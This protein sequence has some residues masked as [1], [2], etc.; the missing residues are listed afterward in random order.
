MSTKTELKPKAPP[1]D[2]AKWLL[3]AAIIVAIIVGNSIYANESPLY[4]VLA[5]LAASALAVVIAKS[6]VL[7]ETIWVTLRDSY[8]EIRRVVWPTKKETNQTAL[9]V[10]VLTLVSA[11]VLLIFDSIFKWLFSFILG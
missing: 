2:W 6:T 10:I 7:G 8:T 4:R 3:V 9:I 11:L 1:L 5:I